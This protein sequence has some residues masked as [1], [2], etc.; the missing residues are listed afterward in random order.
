MH[1]PPPTAQTALSSFKL[2]P[3]SCEADSF[4]AL[5]NEMFISLFHLSYAFKKCMYIITKTFNL[6]ELSHSLTFYILLW[7]WDKIGVL[8]LKCSPGF[9]T[10]LQDPTELAITDGLRTTYKL[11]ESWP[12]TMQGMTVSQW[13]TT[14]SGQGSNNW[15]KT[16]WK[17]CAT[18]QRLIWGT[19]KI[20]LWSKTLL[21][22][23]CIKQW[24]PQSRELMSAPSSKPEHLLK[25]YCPSQQV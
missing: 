23:N 1:P 12:D 20:L 25:H 18:G 5:W 8:F 21:W 19:T 22:S 7:F 2:S 16:R 9:L 15:E 3:S 13:V 6:S 17:V 11:L 14:A 24:Q 10:L 4:H